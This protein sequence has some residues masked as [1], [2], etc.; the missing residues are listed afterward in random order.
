MK[1]IILIGIII[2]IQS[3]TL[4]DNFPSFPM[5][6]YW[7]IE[8]W[9]SPLQGWIIKIFNSL[10]EELITYD[11]TEEWKYW[12]DNVSKLPLLLNEFE[13]NLIFK[14]SYNWKTYIVDSIDDSYKKDVCPDGS[15]I[16]FISANCRYDISLK[17]EIEEDNEWDANA[18]ENNNHSSG[19]WSSHK[20]DDTKDNST[21]NTEWEHYITDILDDNTWDTKSADNDPGNY[22]QLPNNDKEIQENW[23]TKE[24]NDAYQFSYKNWITTRKNIKDVNMQKPLT[25]I[26]AAKMLSQYAM[27]VLWKQPDISKGVIKFNDVTNKLNEEYDNAITLVYQLWIMW[28]N[29]KHF[30]PNDIMTRAEFGTALSRMLYWTENWIDVYY[31]TH[32]N[33][34]KEEWIIKITNPNLKEIKWYAMLMLMRAANKY[35]NKL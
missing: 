19:W 17:E 35:K 12:S 30:R 33:K 23:F 34:L 21:K 24:F 2:L 6:I 31:T 3:F 8:I 27:N 26:V 25:R 11:I 7:N 20:N 29:T 22:S 28:I 16:T 32:L 9:N 4:A 15:S 14:V 18:W 5:T 10:D 1:K 13:W